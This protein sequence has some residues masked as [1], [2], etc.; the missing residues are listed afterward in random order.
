MR[1]MYLPKAGLI[2]LTLLFSLRAYSEVYIQLN[3]SPLGSVKASHEDF[4]N[5]LPAYEPYELD[6][7][8]STGIRL[9]VDI[10]YLSHHR[11]K[12]NIDDSEEK[13]TVDTYSLGL[14]CF[15]RK[16][17]T[18]NTENFYLVGLGAGTGEF[19][20]DNSG[21]NDWELL[22]ELNLETGIIFNNNFT[23]GAGVEVQHFGSFSESKATTAIGYISA[24]FIF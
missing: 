18:N 13:A 9:L 7:D 24:G 2:I 8:T 15:T 20:Y 11:T 5:S 23:L 19:T 6:F 3:F 14:G 21:L 4:D 1:M 17:L 22:L 16:P 12:L 10:A